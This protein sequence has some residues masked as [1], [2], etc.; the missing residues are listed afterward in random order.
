[1]SFSYFSQLDAMYYYPFCF[2]SSWFTKANSNFNTY[3]SH[4]SMFSP[5]PSTRNRRNYF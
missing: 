2:G 1:M 5:Q 3:N 4:V